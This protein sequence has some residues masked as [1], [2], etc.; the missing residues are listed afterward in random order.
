MFSFALKNSSLIFLIKTYSLIFLYRASSGKGSS[1]A[2]Q[3]LPQEAGLPN[4]G[5]SEFTKLLYIK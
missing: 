2:L 3:G 5:F 4:L 1:E